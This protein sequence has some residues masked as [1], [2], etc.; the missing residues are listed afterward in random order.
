ME[1][2]FRC[3]GATPAEAV[4]L[5]KRHCS[6]RGCQ[7]C[8]CVLPRGKILPLVLRD[9]PPF[10]LIS[11]VLPCPSE[12]I[13][14]VTIH[15]PKAR[16]Q[17]DWWF[18]TNFVDF[19]FGSSKPHHST[20]VIIMPYDIRRRPSNCTMEQPNESQQSTNHQR[21]PVGKISSCTD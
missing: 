1:T 6:P 7:T 21:H 16:A 9:L 15:A 8:E 20:V 18:E 12:K 11:T 19:S 2:L 3:L 13:T 17:G 4:N 10:L 5:H 14:R